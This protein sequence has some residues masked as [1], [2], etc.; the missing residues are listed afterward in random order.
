MVWSITH[1]NT[2]SRTG[3]RH[4][5]RHPL[6]CGWIRWYC[7]FKSGGFTSFWYALVFCMCHS[8]LNFLTR[9]LFP[10][11]HTHDYL[12]LPTYLPIQYLPH[13]FIHQLL[14]RWDVMMIINLT[15]KGSTRTVLGEYHHIF[16]YNVLGPLSWLRKTVQGWS[17]GKVFQICQYAEAEN[18]FLFSL[19]LHP[20]LP[21]L[22]HP[23][24]AHFENSPAKHSRL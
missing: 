21:F 9:P 16:L 3:C 12:Y 14:A 18:F 5:R 8:P 1:G 22:T 17:K 10:V 15:R 7:C 2:M 13:S 24:P 20:H 11:S 6:C 19:C 4:F 23:N